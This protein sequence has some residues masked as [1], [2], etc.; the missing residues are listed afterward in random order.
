MWYL[1]NGTH[2]NGFVILPRSHHKTEIMTTRGIKAIA[3]LYLLTLLP[4]IAF[5]QFNDTV[6]YYAGVTAN[7]TINKTNTASSYVANHALRLSVKKQS[8]SLNSTST[9]VYGMLNEKLTNNDFNSALDFNLYKGLLVPHS[10][11]W[12]LATYTSSY[13]LKINNQYQAGAG[14]AYDVVD[15]KRLRFNLSDGILY[16]QS[17]ITLKDTTRDVYNTFRNSFRVLLR[18]TVWETVSLYSMTFYQNSLSNSTDYIFRTNNGLDIKLRKWLSLNGG[19]T[20]NKFSR[21]GK[22]NT[23]FTYGLKVEHYF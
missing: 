9:W 6:N 16:E 23:L 12:G 1:Y 17:D 19:Y 10:Y 5:S 14:V 8:I 13:S 15:R 20:Y 2:H 21:T 7:G 4:I 3:I 11:Y 22:E 18:F